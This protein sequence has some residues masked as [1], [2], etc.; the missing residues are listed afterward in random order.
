MSNGHIVIAG[1]FLVAYIA[2]MVANLAFAD[3]IVRTYRLYPLSVECI[4]VLG[5]VYL[6]FFF[7]SA[8]KVPLAPALD[9]ALLR[10]FIE[11]LGRIYTRWRMAIALAL[12]PVGTASFL[13]GQ[14]S[15]RYSA[16]AISETDY[17]SGGLLL[18]VIVVNVVITV[19]FVY[20]MF[21]SREAATAGSG[22]RFLENMLLALFLVISANG[23]LSLFEALIA[24][25]WSL[26][27]A[28][29]DRLLFAP[30]KPSLVQRG[31]IATGSA[32]V[33][34]VVLIV[35]WYYGTLIKISSSSGGD[36]SL[37]DWDVLSALGGGTDAVSIA[38]IFY[39]LVERGSIFYYSLLF[40]VAAPSVELSYDAVSAIVFPLQTLW[41]RV[42]YLLGGPFQ[43]AKPEVGS[44]AQLN[45]QLLT[46]GVVRSR[47][48]SAPGLIGSFNYVLAFPLNLLCCAAYLRWLANR[49][50]DLLKQHRG[51]MLSP[52][53]VLLLITFLQAF[54]QSPFDFLLVIDD[55]VIYVALLLGVS[56]AQREP[57]TQTEPFAPLPPRGAPRVETA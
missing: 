10:P 29:L 35:A 15:Y 36:A 8:T 3:D 13:A 23:I 1:Y 19:D 47:E 2:P 26:R 6:F 37:L 46:A 33:L 34:L 45:Y 40:T 28:I 53:G 11:R 22:R 17:L 20:R 42:D 38:S 43:M 41:F 25:L 39:Y 12:L 50:D 44:I 56:L 30:R 5:A 52:L 18:A 14:T 16:T 57:R 7:L 49:I 32:A 48:G 24:L 51:R 21:V 4:L 27:P 54:F 31:M 9:A 55:A